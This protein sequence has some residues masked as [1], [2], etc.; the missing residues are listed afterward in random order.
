MHGDDL[1]LEGRETATMAGGGKVA[2]FTEVREVDRYGG[3]FGVGS[4]CAK[5][6]VS[7]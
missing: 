1:D 5:A 3:F 7:N 4:L 2:R 6:P